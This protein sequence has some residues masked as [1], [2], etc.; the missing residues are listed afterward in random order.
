MAGRKRMA[1]TERRVSA[2]EISQSTNGSRIETEAQ[3]IQRRIESGQ[4]GG[5]AQEEGPT[6]AERADREYEA[7]TKLVDSSGRPAGIPITR[8][9]LARG[10]RDKLGKL[11]QKFTHRPAPDA[12]SI[13]PSAIILEDI[14][15]KAY[16]GFKSR[17]YDR[18]EARSLVVAYAVV[19]AANLIADLRNTVQAALR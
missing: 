4:L 10:M 17:G 9:D 6:P 12:R 11:V 7:R 16:E 18:E 19:E 2:E 5:G 13:E 8:E 3:E 15:V 1:I 14:V